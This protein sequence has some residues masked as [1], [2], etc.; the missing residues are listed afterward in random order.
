[1]TDAPGSPE[2]LPPDLAALRRRVAELEAAECARRQAADP[3]PRRTHRPYTRMPQ[4][5]IILNAK[6]ME[7]SG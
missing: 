7:T 5:V 3:G 2:Q 1:M 4:T 6:T